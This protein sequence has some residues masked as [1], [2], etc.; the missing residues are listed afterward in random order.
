M[1][2]AAWHREDYRELIELVTVYL[3]GIV[4]RKQYGEVV[5]IDPYIRKPGALHGIVSIPFEDMYVPDTVPDTVP[6]KIPLKIICGM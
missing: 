1:K 3:G 6:F 5:A 4:K 2:H